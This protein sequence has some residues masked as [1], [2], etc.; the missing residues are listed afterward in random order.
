MEA[1]IF[2][3][4]TTN[5]SASLSFGQGPALRDDVMETD[6]KTNV[7]KVTERW[8]VFGIPVLLSGYCMD[9]LFFLTA[10]C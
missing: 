6:Q 5:F 4:T 9:V 8:L 10:K 7:S 2:R 1:T 3:K